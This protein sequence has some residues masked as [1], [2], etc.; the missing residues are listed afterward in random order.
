MSL[1]DVQKIASKCTHYAMCKIDFLDTGICP[2]GLESQFVAYYPQGRMELANALSQNIIPMTKGVIDIVNSCSLCG[3]C[4]KQCYFNSGLRPMKVM[5]ALKKHVNTYLKEN[6]I[7]EESEEDQ[8]L[9]R[10]KEIVGERWATNDPAI[11]ITYSRDASPFVD[12]RKPQ[13]IVLPG[14][15][16]EVADIIKTAND[17]NI[18]YTLRAS[19]SSGN[20]FALGIGIII[21]F[22]R[23]KKIVVDPENW[24]ASIEPGVTAFELQKE[25]AKHNMRACVA[26]P[27]A[28]VCSNII[29]NRLNSLFSHCYGMGADLIID[30][31][32]VSKEG[33]PFTLTERS[34]IDLSIFKNGGVPS[35]ETCTSL[36]V[37]LFPMSSDEA[38]L[39]VPFSNLEDAMRL[40]RDIARRRIGLGLCVLGVE[41]AAFFMSPT[42]KTK[43]QFQQV[44]KDKLEIEYL[45]L[46]LGDQY[47]LDAVKKMA[48]VTIDQKMFEIIMKSI[49][50]L[51]SNEGL[52]LLSEI[53]SNKKP[54]EVLFKK[55]METLVEA[56]LNPSTENLISAVDEDL[57]KFYEE[58]FQNPNMTNIFW[59][60]M[61]RITTARIG[62]GEHYNAIVMYFSMNYIHLIPEICSRLKAIAD[63]YGVSN[64]FGYHNTIDLGR[65]ALLEYDF[66]HDHTNQE[67]RQN[68]RKAIEE[69]YGMLIT[70]YIATK[71]IK[72]M[73]PLNSIWQGLSRT[74]NFLYN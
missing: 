14:S 45:V 67:Q 61:Y 34:H 15:K 60:N 68:V 32:F 39:F 44:L 22:N 47:A 12:R 5:R 64:D 4:D 43:E 37:K 40:A 71:K 10:L 6:Q 29:M 3:I 17:N 66:Y 28:C 48:S 51:H 49:P 9:R 54:Y 41:Y 74:E 33:I 55:G 62:R 59:L 72:A 26:E 38:G 57:K 69:S 58:L 25:A 16:N 21:D 46:V 56:A 18:P 7:V 11:L 65:W 23:M 53:P 63:K 31:E 52:D 36:T 24:C 13:Y 8:I 20:A 1:V 42:I 35:P 2:S 50:T 19:G 70:E 30:G 73:T 27:A